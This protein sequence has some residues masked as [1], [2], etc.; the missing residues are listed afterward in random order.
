MQDE[1]AP[2]LNTDRVNSL[3][4]LGIA[5]A[6][7]GKLDSAERLIRAALRY[8]PESTEAYNNLGMVLHAQERHEEAMACYE[9]AIARRPL[10]AVALNNLGIT[11]AAL[12]RYAEAI[13]RYHAALAA[14]PDYAAALNNLG[15]ALHAIGQTDD[16]I[17]KFRAAL[18][19]RSDFAE[20]EINLGDA[21]NKL[22]RYA[23]AIGHYRSALKLQPRNAAAYLG[24]AEA[25]H[26]GNRHG[27]AET[28][29]R[30]VIQIHPHLA[31]AYAGLGSVLQEIGR[32][33]EARFCFNKAIESDPSR[34][35][36][37]LNFFVITKS[38]ANDPHLAT[39]L[40]MVESPESLS[41][42]NRIDLH[43]ALGKALT[44]IG[45]HEQGF[46]HIVIGNKLK[47]SVISHNETEVLKRFERT[48]VVFDGNL[49]RHR[50]GVGNPSELPVFIVGMPRSGSTLIEQILVSHPQVSGAGE[51]DA[52]YSAVCSAGLFTRA[53]P[54]PDSVPRWTDDQLQKIG[55]E[56][57]SRLQAASFAEKPHAT[58][59]R[60][61][62]KMLDNFLFIGL[63]HLALPNARIIHV[64]RDPVDT[65]LSCFSLQF[66]KLHFTY[67]L[68]ELGRRYREYARL[69]NHW[70][71]VLPPGIM[72][73]VSYENLVKNLEKEARHIIAYCGLEWNNSCLRFYETNYPVRTSSLEQVRRPIYRDS[74]GRWRPNMEILHSLFEALGMEG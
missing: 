52:F 9:T 58:V 15:T 10:Y 68:G 2:G 22:G 51:T 37:Y 46:E 3:Q 59:V 42:D 43:F 72:L 70:R 8:D 31:S 49:L 33:D 54:F 47:R 48:R 34:L 4:V 60:I 41:M 28:C 62:D 66:E 44:D 61:T 35:R 27:E 14:Q 29:Y 1:P 21:F 17:E 5:H 39:M 40:A 57:V 13:T 23:E 24:L 20:A 71:T 45:Q 65:C 6:Q 53:W 18:L 32:I 25:L 67:D 19:S 12:G 36:Y 26:R 7:Q 30:Q 16:A 64:Y 38:G 69:M 73:E 50:Q 56:Y 74:V 63:I 55:D 11:L